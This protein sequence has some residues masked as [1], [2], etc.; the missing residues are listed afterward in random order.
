MEVGNG[1]DDDDELGGWKGWRLRVRVRVW[2]EFR[3]GG[4]WGLRVR[5]GKEDV[6]VGACLAETGRGKGDKDR[7]DG[8]EDAEEDR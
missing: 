5:A 1:D 8:W 2:G 4:G 6:W 3:G 7:W